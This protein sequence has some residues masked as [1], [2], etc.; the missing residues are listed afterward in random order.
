MEEDFDQD[1]ENFQQPQQQRWSQAEDR[2][3]QLRQ[4]IEPPHGLD[5]HRDGAEQHCCYR[6]TEKRGEEQ[7]SC[8]GPLTDCLDDPRERGEAE[9]LPPKAS[10]E[11]S[12]GLPKEDW[13]QPGGSRSDF[14]P[15]ASGA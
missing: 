9:E 15:R 6:K 14:G 11:F 13:G 2:R 12:V 8:M 5:L 10:E 1:E 7:R 3:T 4:P